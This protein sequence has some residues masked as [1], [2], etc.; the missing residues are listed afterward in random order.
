MGIQ[1]S[2]WVENIVGKDEIARWREM[3]KI[4]VTSIFSFFQQIFQK[5]SSIWSLKL[6][7]VL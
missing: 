7:N 3:E 5:P 2:D 4:L 6:R 1:V